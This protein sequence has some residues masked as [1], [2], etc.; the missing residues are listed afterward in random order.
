MA[1]RIRYAGVVAVVVVGSLA[2]WIWGM[3]PDE[4]DPTP[5]SGTIEEQVEI[6]GP[7]GQPT[8]PDELAQQVLREDSAGFSFELPRSDRNKSASVKEWLESTSRYRP[9]WGKLTYGKTIVPQ[10]ATV[11]GLLEQMRRAIELKLTGIQIPSSRPLDL[12]IPQFVLARFPAPDSFTVY[13]APGL[14]GRTTIITPITRTNGGRITVIP[15]TF[16]AL[17]AS[18]GLSVVQVRKDVLKVFPTYMAR[19]YAKVPVEEEHKQP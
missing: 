2:L 14:D 9:T 12:V 19:T 3:A 4:N 5:T 11:K 16:T 6:Q 1:S 10:G 13:L 7:I 17:L 8:S 18:N 15:Q